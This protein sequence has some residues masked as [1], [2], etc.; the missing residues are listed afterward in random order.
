MASW[1][2]RCL[3]ISPGLSVRSAGSGRAM[4]LLTPV[5][6]SFFEPKRTDDVTEEETTEED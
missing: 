5:L 1:K 6:L 3:N 2:V 4:S